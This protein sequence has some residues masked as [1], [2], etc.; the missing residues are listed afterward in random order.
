M[1]IQ[2]ES[3]LWVASRFAGDVAALAA[4]AKRGVAKAQLAMI[5]M[6]LSCVSC[7]NMDDAI[8]WMD[9]GLKEGNVDMQLSFGLDSVM[10]YLHDE[11]VGP[12]REA[13]KD[14]SMKQLLAPAES[15][16]A[17]AQH[18]LGMLVYHA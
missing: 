7:V 9:R 2:D 18:V 8:N 4:A 5:D 1:A 16:S 11:D 10:T 14:I 17:T 15:G 6:K 3:E 13:T 12:A